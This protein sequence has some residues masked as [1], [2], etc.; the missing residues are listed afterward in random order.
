MS[1]IDPKEFGRIE[2][3]VEAIEIAV[4]RMARQVEELTALANQGRGVFWAGM[5]LA[6][7]LGA[8]VTVL[9]RWAFR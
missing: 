2:A 8:M 5:A 1:E 3:K 7:V 6:S 9:A 4:Q